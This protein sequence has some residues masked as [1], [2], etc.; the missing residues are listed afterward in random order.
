M[1]Q[2]IT[3]SQ[4]EYEKLLGRIGRL[5]EAIRKL[6]RKSEPVHG[7]DEWWTEEMKK[8]DNDIK[9]GRYQTFSNAKDLQIYLD[10]LKK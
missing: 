7:S 8:A 10:S 3:I 9:E 6:L 2:T 1:S 4:T 5:E